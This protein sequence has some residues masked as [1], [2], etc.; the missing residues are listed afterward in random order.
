MIIYLDGDNSPGTRTKGISNL[1]DADTVKVFYARNN[2]HY[3]QKKIQEELEAKCKSR[4]EFIP[5]KPGNNSVDF[6]IAIAVSK[7]L[8]DNTADEIH[9]IVSSDKHF[10]MVI[11][12]LKAVFPDAFFKRVESVDEAIGRFFLFGAD[13]KESLKIALD[14][15]FGTRKGNVLYGNLKEMF[16]EKNKAVVPQKMPQK[17]ETRLMK[18]LLS[19]LSVKAKNKIRSMQE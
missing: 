14:R 13:D 7:Q 2:K 6:A 8:T 9:C 4:F 5:V 3:S 15:L 18:G 19:K 1:K 10:D 16:T 12:N 11:E 17:K